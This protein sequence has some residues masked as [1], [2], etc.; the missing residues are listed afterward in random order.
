[1]IVNDLDLVRITISPPK[2]DPPLVVDPNAMLS[3]AIAFELL[4]PVPWRHAEIVEHLGGVHGDQF[5][6]HRAQ[7]LGGIAPNALTL[8]QGFGMP[9]GEALD[10]LRS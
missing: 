1:M 7:K 8:E 4:E 9:I 10:H 3:R 2:A 6:E 5:A